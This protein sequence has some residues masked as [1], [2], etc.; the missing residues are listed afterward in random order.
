MINLEQIKLLEA[1]VAKTID[2][3]D[4]I[5]KENAALIRRES[6][7]QEKI[8]AYQKRVDELEVLI[9]GF[10]EE[11]GRIEDGFFAVLDKL[12]QFED[13]IEKNLKE[14]HHGKPAGNTA[15]GSTAAG[16][17]AS[18]GNAATGSRNAAKDAI[19]SHGQNAS[20]HKAGTP[21]ATGAPAKEEARH[22]EVPGGQTIEI[23]EDETG[24]DAFD[25]LNGVFAEDAVN[26]DSPTKGGE[27]DIF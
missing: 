26:G 7:L 8:E 12:S 18:G 16:N 24:D 17:A 19:K 23:P 20:A 3:V 10:K 5:S 22:D 11:H 21:V 14:K 27:L 25:S 2:F 6:E 15:A 13:A 4:R 9:K 1:K